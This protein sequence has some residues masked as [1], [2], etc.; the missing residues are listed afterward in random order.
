[1]TVKRKAISKKV[2]FDVFKRDSFECQYCGATPPKAIMHVDHIVPVAEG[3]GN[4]EE[5]LITA[6]SDCN[7]GKGARS[8]DDVPQSITDRAAEIRER[9]AQIVGYQ[10]VMEGQRLRRED[11][12][13][14]VAEIFM[15]EYNL[16]AF[17]KDWLI[18]VDNF[19]RKLGMYESI[20]AAEKAIVKCPYSQWQAFR[21]FCGICWNKIKEQGES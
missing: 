2:R 15:K 14:E 5:N 11:E 9:E 21:Y 12:R 8:L 18:S 4:E 16:D 3:G 19:N 17:P 10:K 1:M 7:L 6:C 13:W 20:D